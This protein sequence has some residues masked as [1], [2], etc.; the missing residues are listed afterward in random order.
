MSSSLL[1]NNSSFFFFF[2]SGEAEMRAEEMMQ[3]AVPSMSQDMHAK[4]GA[5]YGTLQR[6]FA[7]AE[8]ARE[9]RAIAREYAAA[10]HT[11]S[12]QLD[13]SKDVAAQREAV[14]ARHRERMATYGAR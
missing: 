13:G 6:H 3:S 10:Q 9:S 8:A 12:R 2:L 5:Y 7:P 4:L 11:L 1:E 14:R